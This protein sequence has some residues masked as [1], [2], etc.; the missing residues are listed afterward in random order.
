MQKR[1]KLRLSV[2]LHVILNKFNVKSVGMT[3]KALKTHYY[4]VVSVMVVCDTY[5]LI[6]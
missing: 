3:L 5:I 2:V 4:V 1:K 6:A